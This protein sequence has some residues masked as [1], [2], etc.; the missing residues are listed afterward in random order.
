[1][2]KPSIC[3]ALFLH[4]G[5]RSPFVAGAV[6]LAVEALAT[7]ADVAHEARFETRMTGYWLM[8]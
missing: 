6:A 3:G 8:W 7:R 5:P 2:A 4:D 1:M